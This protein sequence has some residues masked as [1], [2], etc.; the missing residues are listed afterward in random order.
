MTTAIQDSRSFAGGVHPP[1]GKHLTEDRGIE[2][3]PPTKELAV[4]LSQHIGAPAQATVK[5]GDVVVAGQQIGEC[6]A[7]VCAPVHSPA[8]GKVKD[9]SLLPHAV[10][11]R[12]LG[13]IIEAESPAQPVPPS[14]QRPAGFDPNTY[15]PERICDAVRNAGIVGMGGAGFPASV[16]IQPDAKVPKETLIVNGCECEPYITCDYRVMLE[17]TEQVITGVQLVA[18][19]CGAKNIYI[20]IED[21]KPKAIERMGDVLQK[22]G[23]SAGIRVVPL[24]TKY[25]QGGERQLIRAVIEKVVPTGGIPPMIGVVVTNV[26]TAAAIADAVV[27]G[28]PLTHRVV[29][30]TGWG[31]ARPGNYYVPI[32]TTVQTLIDH[33]GGPTGDVA[34]VVLGGPMMGIA[35]A[36]L[37]TP[38]TKTG[39]AVMVLTEDQI[40]RDR[41]E[42]RQTPC[43]RC[44]RCLQACPENL[45]PTKIAHAVKCNL[46]DVA[47][48]HFISACI[49]C[50]CCSYVCP[51][52]IDLSG[53][54]KTGKIFLARRKKKMPN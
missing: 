34:K 33:C 46:M 29:T 7:F 54:I 4:L 21:N 39:G 50:G 49:E 32:G 3:G 2:P 19:A 14:F 9:I 10:L 51:A 28:R 1:E 36:D 20:A 17:W 16:K 13:V 37:S 8:A 5:K 47:E 6:K 15:T 30:V 25:P 48:S 40:G 22:L 45:N 23:A 18:R 38:I 41:F 53:Y 11:G 26:A 35:I 43:I 24:K 44:G 52:N 31:I 12:T 42:Q 27:H